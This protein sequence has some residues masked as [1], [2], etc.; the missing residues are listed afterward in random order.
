GLEPEAKEGLALLNQNAFST[1]AATLAIADAERLL[2]ALDVALAL[3]FEAFAANLS[4]LHPAIAEVRPYPGLAA[5]LERV[6]AL[7]DGSYLWV[8]GAARML[9]DPLSFRSAVQVHGAARDV[10]AFARGQLAIELNAAQEN[11]LLVA[12]E[13]R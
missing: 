9:Q 11:P 10:L 2:D 4:V 1:G 6:R 5:T 3:D 8:E 12:G 13:R 7:L